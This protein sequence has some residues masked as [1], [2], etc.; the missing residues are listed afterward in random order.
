[1]RPTAYDLDTFD[2]PY[3]AHREKHAVVKCMTCGALKR[4]LARTNHKLWSE[5]PENTVKPSS[6]TSTC[7]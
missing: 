2:F 6:T 4:F 1:M 3:P 7:E 5:K